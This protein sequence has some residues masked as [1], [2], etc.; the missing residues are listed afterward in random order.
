VTQVERVISAARSL[1]GVCQVDF[2]LPDVCDGGPP[3]T[4]VGARIQDAE[5]RG[6]VFETLG[7]RDR[8]KVYRLL[9]EPDAAPSDRRMALVGDAASN[10][11]SL[12]EPEQ[13]PLFETPAAGAEHWRSEVA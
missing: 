6:F 4:R 3:I 5:E 9:A 12:P 8:C 13:P 11:R 2:L 10:V 7:W 1:D